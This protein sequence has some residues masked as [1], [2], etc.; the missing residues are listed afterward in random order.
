MCDC[1]SVCSHDNVSVCQQHQ[2]AYDSYLKKRKHLQYQAKAYDDRTRWSLSVLKT[3]ENQWKSIED[4]KL[5]YVCSPVAAQTVS[6][7]IRDMCE[8]ARLNAETP[9]VLISYIKN[10]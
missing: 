4:C 8:I 3:K 2:Q 9:S 1:V 6:N 7:I 5:L 10:Q